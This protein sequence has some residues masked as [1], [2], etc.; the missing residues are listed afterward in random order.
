[1]SDRKYRQRGYQDEERDR[2]PRPAVA[3]PA[4][5]PGAPAGA[6]RIS[7][8][9]PRN[10]NMPGFRHVVRCSACGQLATEDIGFN[11]RCSKCGA[12]LH[13]CAQCVSFDPGSRFECSQPVPERVSPK[14]TRNGCTFFSARTTVERETTTPRNNDARKA[15]DDLFNF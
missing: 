1:M 15:F 6:R 11:S 14:N 12:E 10:I 7:Q 8:D 3:R 13:S 9:A 4:P 2:A 5:E